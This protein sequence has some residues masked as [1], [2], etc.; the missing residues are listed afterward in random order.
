MDS[1]GRN[2][3]ADLESTRWHKVTV[4][5]KSRCGLRRVQVLT[6]SVAFYQNPQSRIKPE[7]LPFRW[8]FSVPGFGGRC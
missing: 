2:I 7:Q 5:E 1:V 8:Y 6:I 4:I 3:L